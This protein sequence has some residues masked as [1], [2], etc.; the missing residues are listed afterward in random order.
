MALIRGLA[1]GFVATLNP[2]KESSLKLESFD[3]NLSGFEPSGGTTSINVLNR[4]CKKGALTPSQVAIV[5]SIFTNLNQILQLNSIATGFF[6]RSKASTSGARSGKFL[7]F[8]Q[9]MK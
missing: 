7:P 9:E 1:T 2:S 3:S 5:L 4:F 6:V 8:R